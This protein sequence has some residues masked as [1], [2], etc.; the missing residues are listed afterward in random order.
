M[1]WKNIRF[2]GLT[3]LALIVA[4]TAW[5]PATAQVIV[6]SGRGGFDGPN[7]GTVKLKVVE[8]KTQAP[9][10]YASVYLTAKNDTLITNFTV[11]DTLGVAQIKKVTLG[12]YN[13]F[14]ETKK[15]LESDAKREEEIARVTAEVLENC[16]RNQISTVTGDGIYP[17]K[18]IDFRPYMEKSGLS[19]NDVS[20]IINSAF[21][22]IAHRIFS[23]EPTFRAMY[24]SGGD[25]TVA[26][27]ERFGTAGLRLLDE[28]LPLAA[29]GTFLEGPFDG[30]HII[31][32]GGSQ[33]DSTAIN[34]CITYLKEKLFI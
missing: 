6:V 21:A 15:L 27:C 12:T 29:Y 30:V 19:L 20:G 22:E 31:T 23:A 33:G 8:E 14:V 26:V 32:K 16:G 4:L 7:V 25:I 5:Q 17:D 3:A 34:Q 18:R 9:I 11:T 13:V 28:V 24:T 1:N 2:A 10:P